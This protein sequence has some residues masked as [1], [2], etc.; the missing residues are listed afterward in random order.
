M[1]IKTRHWVSSTLILV[2]LI[3][4]VS[5]S[6]ALEIKSNHPYLGA[7]VVDAATGTVLFEDNADAKGYPASV[8]KLMVLLIILEAVESGHLTLDEPITVTAVASKMGGSQVYLKENEVFPVDELL[9]ALIVKSA[10]DAAAALAIH[11]AGSKEAFVEL[12]NERAQ[13]I[14]MKDTIFHSVHGLPPGW[15]QKP[16]VSTAR[17]IAKLCR[18]LLQKPIVLKYTSTKKRLFRLDAEEPFIME[19]HNELLKTMDGCDGLKTGFFNAAG[20][21][22]AATAAKKGKRA[23]AVVIGAESQKVRDAKTKKI[24]A[25]GLLGLTTDVPPPTPPFSPTTTPTKSRKTP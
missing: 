13:E 9:Y 7:I 20:F 3:C 14:G 4:S 6:A 2:L 18:V 12:M 23:I 19:N 1:I 11:Y 22:I 16:D 5:T 15:R 17:D 8:I 24:L 25:K 10:N 21:S